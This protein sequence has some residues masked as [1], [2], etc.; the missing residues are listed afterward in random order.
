MDAQEGDISPSIVVRTQ[1]RASGP[2]LL[3]PVPTFFFEDGRQEP[4]SSSNV[5]ERDRQSDRDRERHRHRNRERGTDTEAHR[6]RD[7]E[8][9]R[10]T[11]AY[12]CTER[13]KEA[14]G[15]QAF[16]KMFNIFLVAGFTGQMYAIHHS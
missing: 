16:K 9:Q 13:N 5:C 2:S 11:E 4:R 7:R 10:E 8:R 12:T 15:F 6:E 14:F 1:I 3:V